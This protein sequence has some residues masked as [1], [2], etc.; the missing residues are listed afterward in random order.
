M[1]DP[2]K[3][4]Y[5]H[6][7]VVESSARGV[8]P[9]PAQPSLENDKTLNEMGRYASG[10]DFTSD[11]NQLWRCTDDRVVVAFVVVYNLCDGRR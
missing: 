3:L 6:T 10:M 7:R 2:P 9:S 1:W 5:V 11:C 8:Q 4:C